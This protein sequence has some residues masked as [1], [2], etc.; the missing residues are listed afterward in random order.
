L[1]DSPLIIDK[2]NKIPFFSQGKNLS[3]RKLVAFL[4]GDSHGHPEKRL[5]FPSFDVIK[6]DQ[7]N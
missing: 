6:V 2:T 1:K 4:Q 3:A 5:P 7:H